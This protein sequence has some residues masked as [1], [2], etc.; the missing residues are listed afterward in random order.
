MIL[1]NPWLGGGRIRGFI[2]FPKGI[3]PKVGV[4]T[5]LEFELAYNDATVQFVSYYATETPL[6]TSLWSDV[7]LNFILNINSNT[8]WK[9]AYSEIIIT[10]DGNWSPIGYSTFLAF[11]CTNLNWSNIVICTTGGVISRMFI[12]VLNGVGDPSSNPGRR[13]FTAFRTNIFQ[14][15]VNPSPFLTWINSMA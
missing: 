15:G 3:S 13:F 7:L 5:R 4:I 1:L 6:P 8:P 11:S 14:K 2:T 10:V 12:V 9:D